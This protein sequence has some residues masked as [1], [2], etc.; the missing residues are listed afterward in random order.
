MDIRGGEARL[1]FRSRGGKGTITH[2]IIRGI[3]QIWFGGWGD[4]IS[5]GG[6]CKEVKL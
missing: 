4:K 2:Q 6:G 3:V 1:S 5:F